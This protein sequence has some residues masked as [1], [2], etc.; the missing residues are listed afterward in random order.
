MWQADPALA[1]AATTCRSKKSGTELLKSGTEF[2][3]CARDGYHDI[4]D[5][6]PPEKMPRPQPRPLRGLPAAAPKQG[7]LEWNS[8]RGTDPRPPQRR[9]GMMGDRSRAEAGKA[10]L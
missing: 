2:F 10:K 4:E 5:W 3:R 9:E 8:L 1:A 7:W 6:P